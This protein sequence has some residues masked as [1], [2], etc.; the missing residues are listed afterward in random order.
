MSEEWPGLTRGA[1][2]SYHPTEHC[3]LQRGCQTEMDLSAVPHPSSPPIPSREQYGSQ[4]S[5][6]E[7]VFRAGTG[8]QSPETLRSSAE[9]TS[10]D[11]LKEDLCHFQAKAP[12]VAQM[13]KKLLTMQETWIWSLSRKDPLEKGMASHS[14]I[15]AWRIP[16]TKE[17]GGLQFMEFRRVGQYWATNTFIQAK[18]LRSQ[19]SSKSS[20]SLISHLYLSSPLSID[21]KQR[22]GDGGV[23]RWS[24]WPLSLHDPHQPITW[25]RNTFVLD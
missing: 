10:G 16:W 15:L 14:S 13:V 7:Q 20:L 12:L 1:Q 19:G 2:P 11:S 24:S 21:W 9:Q 6:L 25:A 17:P 4:V 3:H 8:V 22:I 23:A 5:L 18:A